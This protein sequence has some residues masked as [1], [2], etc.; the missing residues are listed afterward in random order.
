MLSRD[1]FVRL[2]IALSFPVTLSRTSAISVLEV[3]RE[4]VLECI[5][6]REG[7]GNKERKYPPPPRVPHS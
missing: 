2:L 6:S 5:A 1:D 3:T 4:R 7:R